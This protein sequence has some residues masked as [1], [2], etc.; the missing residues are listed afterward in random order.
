MWRKQKWYLSAA[1]E[2]NDL[3]LVGVFDDRVRPKSTAYDFAIDLDRDALQRQFEVFKEFIE[4]EFVGYL[5][6]FTV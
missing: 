3:D 2:M 6:L 4:R 1:D 5:T